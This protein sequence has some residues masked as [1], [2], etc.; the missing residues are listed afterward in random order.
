MIHDAGVKTIAMGG[1]PNANPIQGMGGVKGAQSFSWDDI[2]DL[3]QMALPLANA[4]QAAILNT[5]SPLPILRA[6]STSVNLRDLIIPSELNEQEPAQFIAEDADCR[7]YW[8]A[9][10]ITDVTKV[11]EAAADAA[12]GEGKCV[13]GSIQKRDAEDVAEEV[14][15]KKKLRS[16]GSEKLKRVS[17]EKN[18]RDAPAEKD[19]MW[20]VRHGRKVVE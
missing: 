11:W 14:E 15:K 19:A 7:L 5:F 3:A 20:S 2:Y 17:K 1:R 10:M 12:W 6:S 16:T 18:R 13:A 4:E 8:T 9:P